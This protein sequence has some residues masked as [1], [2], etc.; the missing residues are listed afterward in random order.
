MHSGEPVVLALVAL[1]V[2][3]GLYAY[4][5]YPA[6]MALIAVRAR[7][8]RQ[9][10]QDPHGDWPRIT[11][12]VVAHNEAPHIGR[13]LK[14]L[15]SADYP[16]DRTQILVVSDASSDDTDDI[17]RGFADQGVELVRMETRVGKTRAENAVRE[18]IRGDIVVN[19][20]AAVL[21]SPDAIKALVSAF[22]NPTVGVA[23]SVDVSVPSGAEESNWGQ[24]VYVLYEMWLRELESRT[25]GIVNASGSLFAVRR[26]LHD[27]EVPAEGVRDFDSA[28]NAV[29][30]GYQAVSVESA[31]CV[32][33]RTR[34]LAAEYRRK[35]RTVG[36]GL[37]TLWP[38]RSLLNPLVSG[39]FAWKLFSRK[40]CR[41]LLPWMFM[42]AIVAMAFAEEPLLRGVSV[43]SVAFGLL[44]IM[45]VR[46]WPGEAGLPR[47]VA[48]PAHGIACNVAVI[49]AVLAAMLGQSVRV[50]EPTLRTYGRPAQ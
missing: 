17:V 26:H 28:L 24:S 15:L 47:L 9:G 46:F 45:V 33:P 29:A 18:R 3:V 25:G 7:R 31:K 49:H 2:L 4:V 27:V 34:D 36:L 8:R 32:V 11:I 1:P 14:N 42:I 38:R 50:W 16:R 37:H 22:E 35:V 39:L 19:T 44:C 43:A 30:H 12:A 13:T 10:A 5:G 40:L 48:L 20:D 23:S 21:A 6:V 41:W